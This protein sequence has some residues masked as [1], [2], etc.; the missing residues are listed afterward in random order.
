M[1]R[2]HRRLGY[3]LVV[4]GVVLVCLVT[5]LIKSGTLVNLLADRTIFSPRLLI[6]QVT[7]DSANPNTL[8]VGVHL[9]ARPG[10]TE[11]LGNALIKNA[12]GDVIAEG[13]VV[14][15]LLLA[16]TDMTLNIT[17]NKS[18]PSGSYRVW[19]QIDTGGYMPSSPFTIP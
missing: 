17:L 11:P 13:D 7:L 15:N 3:A 8:L 2:S 14:P 12:E 10:R 19:L 1:S 4:L 16:N 18:L 9:S 6:R 5:Y